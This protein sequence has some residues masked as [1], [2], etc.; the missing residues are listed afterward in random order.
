M[1]K[2]LAGKVVSTIVV[3]MIFLS[4]LAGVIFH[5][6]EKSMLFTGIFVMGLSIIS[7]PVIWYK[8]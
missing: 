7:L 8:D 4:G 6:A 3:L 5:N 2:G 1:K